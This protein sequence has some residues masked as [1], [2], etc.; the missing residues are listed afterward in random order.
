MDNV[1]IILTFMIYDI[2]NLE[3]PLKQPVVLLL[4]VVV[5]PRSVVESSPSGHNLLAAQAPSS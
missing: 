4:S 1:S 2:A 5:V 3:H